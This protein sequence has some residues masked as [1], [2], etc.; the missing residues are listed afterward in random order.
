MASLQRNTYRHDVDDT[1]YSDDDGEE[2]NW[3]KIVYQGDENFAKTLHS[4]TSKEDESKQTKGNETNRY[5]NISSRSNLSQSPQN[6][7]TSVS[8]ETAK[9]KDI[10]WTPMNVNAVELLQ[11]R[12]SDKGGS[13]GIT[14]NFLSKSTTSKHKKNRIAVNR[15][16]STSNAWSDEDDDD[17]DIDILLTSN[18]NNHIRSNQVKRN[19]PVFQHDNNSINLSSSKQQSNNDNLDDK[20]GNLISR[21]R[22][23]AING[24]HRIKQRSPATHKRNDNNKKARLKKTSII[25]KLRSSSS[26]MTNNTTGRSRKSKAFMSSSATNSNN[27]FN[28][29]KK[30]KRK[31]RNWPNPG[32]IQSG[33]HDVKNIKSNGIRNVHNTTD[34]NIFATTTGDIYDDF[35]NNNKKNN[36][37]AGSF[38]NF[39]SKQK[40]QKMNV[41][42]HRTNET[43]EDIIVDDDIGSSGNDNNNS[44]NSNNNKSHVISSATAVPS[45]FLYTQAL[46]ER[47]DREVRNKRNNNMINNS[48]SSPLMVT[49]I[50]N[51]TSINTTNSWMNNVDEDFIE[52]VPNSNRSTGIETT[53]PL[54]RHH[55]SPSRTNG[56]DASLMMLSPDNN[57]WLEKNKKKLQKGV[58]G[59]I[60][61]TLDAFNESRT[62]KLLRLRIY[63][64]P[65]S[66]K[67][68]PD[69]GK[70]MPSRSSSSSGNVS[71]L[72]YGASI[73]FK[74]LRVEQEGF[75]THLH[76]SILEETL[77][78]TL[79]LM[80]KQTNKK[81]KDGS[82]MNDDYVPK[83]TININVMDEY[84]IIVNTTSV[85]N[86]GNVLIGENIRMYEPWTIIREYCKETNTSGIIIGN[87]LVLKE[88]E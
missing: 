5:T 7:M 40:R 60:S 77:T 2:S 79:Q 71:L 85:E 41:N 4:K 59:A 18:N 1:N 74:V 19:Q 87:D 20:N 72:E 57:K 80:K 13:L 10:L 38:K 23:S 45:Q 25:S 32:Q 54:N 26:F 84:E 52:E 30:I 68:L 44:S 70:I 16:S 67:K 37:K 3:D 66:S 81:R 33:K 15:R 65:S 69:G 39:A 36:R 83:S 21:N 42:V 12:S 58:F 51:G 14:N 35:D 24:G 11:K 75:F 76:G 73:V 47:K 22:N 48:T 43:F 8:S 50:S 9:H 17:D 6:S 62:R 55:P 61:K 53:S 28:L 56:G 27:K 49:R 29:K 31:S 46:M 63:S 78:K 88:K 64:S 86:V 34:N 82:N